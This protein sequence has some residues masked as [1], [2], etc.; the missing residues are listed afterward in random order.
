MGS[1]LRVEA[2]DIDVPDIARRVLA[3]LDRVVSR[4]STEL[5]VVFNEARDQWPVGVY[6]TSRQRHEGGASFFKSKRVGGR[7]KRELTFKV[8][9]TGDR[10]TASV[11]SPTEYTVYIKAMKLGGKNPWQELVRKPALVVAERLATE[12]A[13]ELARL[14]V[15]G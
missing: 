8:E 5:E 12:L 6:G 9:I 10:L 7:S 15:G 13:P 2:V 14:A 3:D 4:V 1:G 11:V